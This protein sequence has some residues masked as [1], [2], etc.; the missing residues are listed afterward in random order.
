M[1]EDQRADQASLFPKSTGDKLRE[2]REAKGMTLAEIA[3]VTRIPMRHLESIEQGQLDGMP[4]PT[5]AIG[6]AKAYARVVGL[7]EKAIGL[8]MRGNPALPVA[9]ATDYE[10]YEV[11]DPKRLP[12]RGV[13]LV[14]GAIAVAL[15]LG[16]AIWFGS[17]LI[18]RGGE[19][20]AIAPSET[21]SAAATPA[22]APTPVSGGQVTLTATDDVWLRIYDATGK[23]LFEKQMKAGDKYD[24]PAD[25]NNPMINVGRPDKVQVLLNG[26]AVAPLGDGSRPIKDVAISAAALQAR[27]AGQATPSGSPTP[28]ATAPT[29]APSVPRAFQSPKPEPTSRVAPAAAPTLDPAIAPPPTPA[30]TP[31]P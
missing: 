15:L 5:Y 23:V 2:A 30:S 17:G 10:R 7:D 9:P 25:A 8:E 4:S 18:G 21:P 28:A 16:V 11:G 14:A 29:T 27:R 20:A 24:V 19:T 22:P 13:V 6:F 31:A 12:S 1:D 3:N 26:S